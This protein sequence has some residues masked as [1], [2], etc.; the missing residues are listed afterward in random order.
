MR[1][2]EGKASIVTGGGTGIGEAIAKCFALEGA[3]VV[4]SGLP[5]DP[6]EDVAEEIRQEGGEAVAF[7]GDIS[8]PDQ[9]QA[10]V[11]KAVD[12][13][14]R[15]DVL[16]NNAAVYQVTGEMQDIPIEDIDFIHRN[17]I[18]SAVLMTK[19][20][21]PAIRQSR[22]NV[23]FTASEAG[24]LGQPKSTI[25]GGTKAY[26]M[27][28]ARGLAVEQA[29]YGV[30]VNVVCPG[31]T[32][33]QWHDTGVSPTTEEMESTIVRSVPLGRHADPEEVANVFAFLASDRASF[34]TGALYFVD[35]GISIARGYPGDEVPDELKRPPKGRLKLRHQMQG[36]ENV[37]THRV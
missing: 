2:L 30:R 35:G 10:C 15:L 34:V 7:G 25:Y 20:G 36:L 37:N 3:R 18:R 16:V 24:A 9:A 31:P 17:N 8:E 19:Y 33:T 29:R 1:L 5:D 27:G 13:F 11:R 26:L 6:I 4:V 28:Y 12:A 32:M 23:L 21:L 22:G 14:G